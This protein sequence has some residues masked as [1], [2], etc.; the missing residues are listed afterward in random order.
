MNRRSLLAGIVCAAAGGP[1]RALVVGDPPD[2]PALHV[3]ANTMRS[4]WA[5][6][7]SVLTGQG[8]YSGVL[9]SRRHVLTAG[10]VAPREPAAASFQLNVRTGEPDLLAV[11]HI[12]HHPR[13]RGFSAQ[14]PAFDLAIVELATDAPAGVMVHPIV[15]AP[16]GIGVP[17][18]IVGYG[19]S[20]SGTTGATISPQASVKRV[21]TAIIDHLAF[22]EDGRPLLY[23]FTFLRG[24]AA[25]KPATGP[26]APVGLAS[27]DSGSACFVQ[28]GGRIGLL[29]VNTYTQLAAGGPHFGF[30]TA[31]GGQVLSA[32]LDWLR[33]VIG[34]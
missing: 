27:G 16:P 29:G 22:G 11:R 13:F 15:E 20:G 2:S 23:R 4:R 24:S 25:R 18:V 14:N 6:V 1:A 10:H 34:A 9:V 30:G 21:G 12:V 28:I 33:S 3:D 5:G 7:G 8:V 26:T 17:V 32:H 31:G 19:A